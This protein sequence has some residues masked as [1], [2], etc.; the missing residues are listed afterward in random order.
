MASKRFYQKDNL[1][2]IH[3][4]LEQRRLM[5]A[6][7]QVGAVW[8]ESSAG[9][10]AMLL[11]VDALSPVYQSLTGQPSEPRSFS[12]YGYQSSYP[13]LPGFTGQLP[14]TLTGG[15]LLG[16]GYRLYLPSL[17]RFA[18][19]DDWSPFGSAGINGYAYCN[20]DPVNHSDPS[21]H[22]KLANLPKRGNKF[23]NR[24][25][26][27]AVKTGHGRRII[28]KIE[29]LHDGV[30][31]YGLTPQQSSL[32]EAEAWMGKKML[33]ETLKFQNENYQLLVQRRT[34]ASTGQEGS[35]VIFAETPDYIE[36]LIVLEQGRALNQIKR[37]KSLINTVRSH[38]PVQASS[39][40]IR[41]SQSPSSRSDSK[42]G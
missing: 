16:N 21:G 26:Y 6:Y 20:G 41:S 30:N 2:L 1:A 15:Y 7:A 37:T 25:L 32:S 34:R 3:N 11:A 9:K 38:Q 12:V 27:E 18:S 39:N 31:K 19:F 14:E 28:K 35:R 42:R 33:R 22:A 40:N 5:N 4:A 23:A 29:A 36:N 24:I 17:M 13:G 10:K 8:I